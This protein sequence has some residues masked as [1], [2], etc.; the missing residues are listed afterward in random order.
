MLNELLVVLLLLINVAITFWALKIGFEASCVVAAIQAICANLFVC[1][2]ICL[3]GLT[4]TGTDAYVLAAMLGFVLIRE[5]FGVDHAKKCIWFSLGSMIFFTVV[6]SLHCA[7]I[8]AC[9]DCTH[10]A[11]T[12]VLAPLP[13]LMFAS[14]GAFAISSFI[15]IWLYGLL[16]IKW[17]TAPVW[18]RVTGTAVCV[19]TIDTLIFGFVGLYGLVAS[20][21]AIMAVSLVLK[22][23]LIFVQAPLVAFGW[24]VFGK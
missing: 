19:H 9:V 20:L 12:V 10:A 4:L 14:I 2:Q 17:P 5:K 11:W 3:C 15:D 24:K 21:S 16:R 8:P 22:Y 13:R 6:S 23:V 1:K 7:F 18:I